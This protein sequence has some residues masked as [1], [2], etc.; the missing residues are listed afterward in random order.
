MKFHLSS[1]ILFL[2]GKIWIPR[3]KFSENLKEIILGFYLEFTALGS[4]ET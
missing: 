2:G 3:E 4:S 1:N